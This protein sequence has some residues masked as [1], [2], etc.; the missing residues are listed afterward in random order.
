MTGGKSSNIVASREVELVA[1]SDSIVLRV[2]RHHWCPE[3]NVHSV[4]ALGA[5]VAVC[6]DLVVTP[7]ILENALEHDPILLG[8]H[9]C[10]AVTTD[11][12]RDMR[13]G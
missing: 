7:T 6:S 10:E 5:L 4:T 8:D 2:V 11:C 12:A 1:S 3:A 13:H 9:L